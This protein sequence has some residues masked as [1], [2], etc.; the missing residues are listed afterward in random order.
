MANTRRSGLQQLI[1]DER[2]MGL[3]GQILEVKELSKAFQEAVGVGDPD[4]VLAVASALAQS[5][6]KLRKR[7]RSAMTPGSQA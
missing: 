1:R 2:N 4:S 3:A 7:M 5:T 6:A